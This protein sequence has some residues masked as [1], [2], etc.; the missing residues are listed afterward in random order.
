MAD[1]ERVEY[2]AACC[3]RHTDEPPCEGCEWRRPELLPANDDA[4]E[5]WLEIRTQWRTSMAGMVGLDYTA[6]HLEAE[7]LDL[8]LSRDLTRKIKALEAW[9]LRQ[10]AESHNAAR[11]PQENGTETIS[12]GPR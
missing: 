9:T 2:C 12:Q 1:R 4:L 10:Q 11:T 5:L 3:Q 6:L 8:P 7:R